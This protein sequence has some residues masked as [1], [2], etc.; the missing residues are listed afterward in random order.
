[1]IF[2]GICSYLRSKIPSFAKIFAPMDEL[3]KQIDDYDQ[4]LEELW[5][6]K[7]DAA[8]LKIKQALV[9][10]NVLKEPRYDRPFVIHSD[11][12]AEGMGAVLMQE[13]EAYKDVSSQWQLKLDQQK[14]DKPLKRI[15][16]PIAYA[17]RKCLSSESRYSAH[18]GELAAAKF[19]LDKFSSFTFGQPIVLVTDCTALR[20]I[21]R[22]EK[23][24]VAHA[25]W[26]EQLL[27]H[28]IIEV[29]HCEG[30]W[31]LLAHGLS[32][33]PS[34][35]R[36]DPPDI[37]EDQEHAFVGA[38]DTDEAEHQPEEQVQQYLELDR[39]AGPL[40]ER[41]HNDELEPLLRFLLLLE[42]P[43]SQP[44]RDKI[45]RQQSYVLHEGDLGYIHDDQV[46]Q[47][48]PRGEAQILVCQI[49]EQNHASTA[50]MINILQ[51][52]EGVMWPSM[53]KDTKEVVRRCQVCQQFGPRRSTTIDPVVVS[54]PMQVWAMDF[55]S[56]PT[57]EGRSKVLVIVDYFSRF[58]WAYA[59]HQQ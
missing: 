44:L 23:M 26:R 8:F 39:H 11:W 56:L 29:R 6:D 3:T 49:H 21:L 22:S 53:F 32:H 50:T 15:S 54:S 46:L 10:S 4:S 52:Q 7:H 19:A 33:R 12:S 58:V 35:S 2:R 38:I 27:A 24:P 17:S 59:Y 5:T 28:N 36:D 16:Y 37:L 47:A 14:G 18:L 41:F 31:H 43:S 9:N 25:R 40:L 20:D 34:A 51:L 57:S 30:R 45:C 1:M 55:I 13:Y 42:Q 48:L